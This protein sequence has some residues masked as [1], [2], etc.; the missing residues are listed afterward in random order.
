MKK[1][2][3][4][5][6]RIEKET[7]SD[8]EYTITEVY[9]E[10]GSSVD[11]GE[12]LFSFET[13]K[14]DVDVESGSQGILY[15]KLQPNMAVKVGDIA[16]FITTIEIADPSSLFGKEV[17]SEPESSG[18]DDWE[19]VRVSES[20]MKL[21]Q[22]HGLTRND[23]PGAKILR[24]KEIMKAIG[25]KDSDSE[26]VEVQPTRNYNNVIIIGGKGGAKMV[27]EAIKSTNHLGI[28]GIIDGQLDKGDH[29]MG[30]PVLGGESELEQLREK[31]FRNVILS[32]SSLHD[33]PSRSKKYNELKEKGFQFPNVIHDRA[34][35]EPSVTL[36]E[37]NIILANAMVGS[38]VTLGNMNYVNTGAMICHESIAHSNNHFAP[39]S[40]IAGRV[41]IGNNNLVGMC[42]TTYFEIEMGDNIIINNGC[43]IVKNIKSNQVIKND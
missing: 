8:D 9:R 3:E 38:E 15:H 33:L 27:I 37:G 41:R 35:V 31:G 21:I 25:K 11:K 36:G 22:E 28:E 12:L 13:S 2:I 24:E 10:S 30:V 7:V 5:T 29:V 32:F 43:N 14:A 34:T 16:A 17:T 26:S 39:N 19:G 1:N 20:A 42:V 4:E 23:F 6:I 18:S 40:V